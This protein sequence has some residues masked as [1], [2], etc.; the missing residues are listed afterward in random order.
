MA[1]NPTLPYRTI[2]DKDGNIFVFQND[3]Y[4]DKQ[5]D[6]SASIPGTV[7]GP[8]GLSDAMPSMLLLGVLL[9][10]NMNS[11]VDQPIVL[12]CSK[13]RLREILITNASVS[14]T[15]AVGGIYDAASKG[16]NALVPAT[17]AFNALTGATLA[18]SPPL[19]GVT[20]QIATAQTIFLSLTTGQGAAA[21]ADIYVYGTEL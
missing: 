2:T 19:T 15:T 13:Y 17:Q 10:A 4:Y 16:G 1:F 20:G 12:E 9:G 11:T 3:V 7:G 8:Y 6:S 21:T 14:L 5:G 18:I